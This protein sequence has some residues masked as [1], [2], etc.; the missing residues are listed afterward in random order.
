[1][2]WGGGKVNY[3]WPRCQAIQGKGH[4]TLTNSDV[5]SETFQMQNVGSS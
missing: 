4:G 5:V 3:L 1:M 2:E